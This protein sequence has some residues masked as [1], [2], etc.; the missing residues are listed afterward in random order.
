LGRVARI[1]LLIPFMLWLIWSAQPTAAA[2]DHRAGVAI[3]LGGYV[4]LVLVMAAWGRLLARQI[5]SSNLQN[6]LRRF[7]TVMSL[8]RMLVVAW[9]A[10]A[11]YGGL[12]WGEFV[13]RILRTQKLP[14]MLPQTILATAPAFLAWV[15]LW[16][17]QFP[18]DRALREQSLL[19]ALEDDLPVHA[20]PGFARYFASQLRLQILFTLIPIVM[21][22]FLRDL[23]YTTLVQTGAIA[24]QS[25][26]AE[27]MI[28]MC[29]SIS[30][31]VIAPAILKHV[32]RTQ[33]LP[34][35]PLRK[36]L[37]EMCRRSRLRYRDILVWRTDNNMGNAAVMG[38]LPWIRYILLS[39]LLLETMTDEQVE[40]VFAHEVGHIVHRHMAWYVVLV[41][42]LM[43]GMSAP[44]ET[45]KHLL[46]TSGLPAWLVSRIDIVMEAAGVAIFFGLFGV[47]SRR[48]ERQA[49]VYAARTIEN[50]RAAADTIARP[51]HVG[52]YG[53]AVF[54]SALHRVAII[55]NIPIGAR[56]FSHGS[57]AARMK[58]L[59]NLSGDPSR[60]GQFDRMML[61]IYATLITALVL[62]GAAAAVV[63]QKT[64]SL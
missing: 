51:S 53:A 40:A 41:V 44:A 61:A 7:N 11:L 49:D 26:V 28:L 30:V 33:P 52:E 50:L 57:I 36:K 27:P 64:G 47:L 15:G 19:F 9:F 55:N 62:C 3:F 56:N 34:D 23:I 18:A 39:D 63:F 1:L 31:F 21:I 37:E 32:L 29:S 48:F 24:P 54:A 38:I 43:L 17:S 12:G 46:G 6:S 2:G 14:L 59:H 5:D 25:P 45:I 42:I 20:P 60:T 4:G 13:N 22:L 58:Y 35:S 16:W 10:M 8:S